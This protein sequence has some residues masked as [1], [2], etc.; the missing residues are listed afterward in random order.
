VTIYYALETRSSYEAWSWHGVSITMLYRPT[1]DELT[2]EQRRMYAAE[3]LFNFR[4]IFKVLAKRSTH[5][6]TE[7]DLVSNLVKAE[8]DVLGACSE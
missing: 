1:N 2:E 6:L 7:A 4:W 8:L 5:I 3:Q